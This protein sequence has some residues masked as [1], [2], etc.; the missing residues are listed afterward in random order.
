[1]TVGVSYEI[2]RSE[3]RTAD[4]VIERD[5]R[6]VVRAPR[7]VDDARVASVV[8]SKRA[9]IERAL[10][11]WRELNASRIEREYRNGE[12]FLYWGRTVRLA[13]VDA[14]DV[15]GA[16]RERRLPLRRDARARAGGEGGGRG[17]RGLQQAGGE[18]H[19]QRGGGGVGARGG[20]AGWGGGAWGRGSTGR[21][22]GRR[23]QGGSGGQRGPRG[24]VA[25]TASSR[26]PVL[27]VRRATPGSAR[28]TRRDHARPCGEG[29]EA[30]GSPKT[31]GAA[32]ALPEIR[33]SG[34]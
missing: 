23:R 21:N 10:A 17:L 4:I 34:R 1:M 18:G 9:W 12:G 32:R 30:S 8:A 19:L 5:G 7:W 3:R 26:S 6:V 14:P 2:L 11:E 15:P 16:V 29:N 24:V 28:D 22:E 27:S 31:S 20:G 25:S 33:G 13:S